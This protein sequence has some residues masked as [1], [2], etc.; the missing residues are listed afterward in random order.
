MDRDVR[1]FRRE[2]ALKVAQ[3]LGVEVVVICALVVGGLFAAGVQVLF[4]GLALALIAPTFIV[5]RLL[6]S[7]AINPTSSS[8]L[9]RWPRPAGP[10]IPAEP[11]NTGSA[12]DIALQ[13]AGFFSRG[14][15]VEWG[16]ATTNLYDDASSRLVMTGGDADVIILTG[17][18][19][20]RLCITTTNLIP[21]HERLIVNHDRQN[22]LGGLLAS[23]GALLDEVTH[24]SAA[25]RVDVS[26]H[27]VVQLLAIEWDAWDQLGPLYG[28]FVAV[29][30]RAQPSLLRVRV[31]ATDI[32][33]RAMAPEP[34]SIVVSH[35]LQPSESETAHVEPASIESGT[36]DELAQ[37]IM[38]ILEPLEIAEPAAPPTPT[39]DLSSLAEQA[40]IAGERTDRAI[41]AGGTQT[42][43]AT[44]LDD[45]SDHPMSRAS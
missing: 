17:L 19:D 44:A 30:N 10:L 16:G 34:A 39:R 41:A 35:E 36:E 33:S 11:T 5:L 32:R 12:V 25:R 20:G 3:R 13:A 15:F 14:A 22:D 23:H 7:C 18:D 45:Q 43:T 42:S 26:A 40:R 2:I 28:P 29:G 6:L 4:I 38:R 9:V 1:W 24:S 8:Y 27:F 37:E 21:P 31:P